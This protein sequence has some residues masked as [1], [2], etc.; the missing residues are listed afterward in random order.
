LLL[1]VSAPV[2][3]LLEVGLVPVQPPEAVQDVAFV[4]DQVSVEDAP[5]ATD[6][7]LAAIDTVG[8]VEL[9]EAPACLATSPPAPPPPQAINKLAIAN[10]SSALE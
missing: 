10:N 1:A 7:G 5:D 3:W 9:P 6:A 4:E 2:D 8:L